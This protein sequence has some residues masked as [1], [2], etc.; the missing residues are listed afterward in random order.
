MK[1]KCTTLPRAVITRAMH[2]IHS[3]R[4]R[5]V[6]DAYFYCERR[7]RMR[8][9]ILTL[10]ALEHEAIIIDECLIEYSIDIL[11]GRCEPM[12]QKFI[13]SLSGKEIV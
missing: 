5:F 6:Y 10:Q 4:E 12:T 2:R 9:V 8:D 13:K 1:S 11:A 3:Q 7:P